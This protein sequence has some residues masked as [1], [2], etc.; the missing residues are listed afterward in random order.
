FVLGA[1]MAVRVVPIAIEFLSAQTHQTTSFFFD[2][3][4]VYLKQRA[5]AIRNVWLGVPL[6]PSGPLSFENV[7]YPGYGWTS[8]L[9]VLA[10]VQYLLG[11]APY[12][13]HLINIALFTTAV[14]V[15]YRMARR[16]YG[17][18]VALAGLVL[19]C[20]LPTLVAWSASALKES[21]YLFV[22]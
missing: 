18:I 20:F 12:G 5:L 11:P 1:A 7:F 22:N 6:P 17:G 15:L 19:A 3:D 16:S 4:G 10:Y 13:V 8:Y 14:V 2:G 21:I 9:Y